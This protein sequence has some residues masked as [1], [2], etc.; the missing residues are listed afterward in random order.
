MKN[1]SLVFAGIAP[2]PPIMVP[3]IGQEETIKVSGSIQ[4]MRDFSQRVIE[5]GAETV[6]IVSP[7]APL[8]DEGF[9]AYSDPILKGDFS[10]FGTS[11]TELSVAMDQELFDLITKTVGEHGYKVIPIKGE[12]LDHGAMVPLYFLL[13]SGWNGRAVVFGYSFLSNKDHLNFGAAIKRAIDKSGRSAALIA[14][15]DLSHRLIPEAPAG[16]YPEAHRFD[17]E[18]VDSIRASNPERIINIDPYLRSQ[19]GEC[20]YRSILIA[21]GATE[22]L[23]QDCEILHYEAPFGVGYLV[24]Q[25]SHTANQ[26]YSN[27]WQEREEP[28][29]NERL[30]TSLARQAVESYIRDKQFISVPE[31]LPTEL[32]VPG[33]CFVSIKTLAGELRGCIG[34]I[35]PNKDSLANEIISNAISAAIRDPR[36]APVTPMELKDLSYSV[37]ILMPPEPAHFEDLNPKI[38][39]VIVEDETGEQHGLLLPDIPG[40]DTAKEQVQIALRKAGIDPND[41]YKL[42]RFRV[43]RFNESRSAL[44]KRL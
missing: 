14:S 2:H 6:I 18:I 42:Y 9:I 27:Y 25:L 7:H 1:S 39:G 15:G 35:E 12:A 21:L 32:T 16:Y 40:I 38:Y 43:H 37:D 24:A 13:D 22:D 11:G 36:F 30:V 3:E 41:R 10:R 26:S 23:A 33:A 20:G 29:I 28:F 31:G 17:K 19:A 8:D 5:S 44:A 34:T 4:G